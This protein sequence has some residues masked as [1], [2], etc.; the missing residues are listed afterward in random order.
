[1]WETSKTTM[2]DMKK[3]ETVL[4]NLS[5]EQECFSIE[6]TIKNKETEKNVYYSNG[7]LKNLT[8]WNISHKQ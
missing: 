8:T 6:E 3:T 1:M 2:D 4:K 7:S 5:K